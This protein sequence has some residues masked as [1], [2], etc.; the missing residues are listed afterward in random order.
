MIEAAAIGLIGAL[1]KEAAARVHIAH[2]T[3]REALSALAAI[4]S[5]GALATGETCPQYLVLDSTALD[6]Y[7]GIAKIAPPLRGPADQEALWSA[8]AD[9]AI[10]VVASDHAP[11][12]V[13]Q[14]KE[15]AFDA[16][17]LGLPT[18]ELLVPVLLNAAARGRLPLPLAVSLVTTRPA[19][20]FGLA[21]RKGTISVGA[22][23]DIAV[24]NLNETYHPTPD[25]L[26]SRGGG[27]GVV[28]S[29]LELRARITTTI[30]N[31]A[32]VYDSRTIVG[33]RRGEFITP[34]DP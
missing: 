7:G 10:D 30:V 22:D 29:D 15:V 14:K 31:G 13:E 2:V 19:E 16:A 21:G 9:G 25:T 11:F 5:L 27:C 23:A 4:Q 1:A 34:L 26:L 6:R 32:I 33:E 20:L 8:L 17:P 3:S 12:P 18:V 24:A 28:Y